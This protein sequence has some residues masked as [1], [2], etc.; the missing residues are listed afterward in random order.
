[1]R[2][3]LVD[4]QEKIL[5][6]TKKLV[7]WNRLGVEQVFTANS[8]ARARRLLEQEQIDIMLADI[9]M[10][11]ENGIELQ[12]WVSKVYPQVACI[13]LTSHADFS[14][15]QEAI[16]NGAVDYILQ[17]A[18]MSSI[19]A[20]LEK[21]IRN[22]EAK[23][24]I[25]HKSSSYDANLKQILKKYVFALFHQGTQFIQMEE[26][27]RDS[28]T[29]EE[30]WQYLPC[31]LRVY[32]TDSREIEERLSDQVKNME[33]SGRELRGVTSRLS[34]KEIGILL[35]GKRPCPERS[36]IESSLWT[37]FEPRLQN[38]TLYMGRCGR[39][40]LP[41]LAQEIL[42]FKTGRMLKENEI[43]H[44][45][46]AIPEEIRQPDSAVWGRWLIRQDLPL[47]KNQMT[48]LLHMAEQEKYLTVRYM[49]KL[50]YAFLE[51]CSVACYEQKHSL[52]ELFTGEFSHE[53]MLRAYTSVEELQKGIDFCLRRYQQM[54]GERTENTAASVQER[55]QEI[56][57]YLEENMDRMISR[58][59]AAKYVFLNED[60]FSRMFRRETGM[61]YKEYVVKQKMD[62]AEKL[63]ADTDMPIALVASKV[64]YD[65]YTNFTQTFRKT[66]GLT[67]TDYRKKYRIGSKS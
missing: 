36:V 31:L 48:N 18:A 20:A 51:A 13:F 64:G 28:H 44:V 38:K 21:C 46:A 10:P 1:M 8:G 7:N 27:K 63:L 5:E 37:L 49:Q 43:Y 42:D 52:G 19:E 54:F 67:P 3:L 45:D 66:K 33:I 59:E 6:A 62:Y 65:N 39:D 57:H 25:L 61:G 32:D 55:I 29:G 53:D 16:R 60:Y 26:W 4:D 22:L 9:E 56:L 35:Y 15:A 47:V 50:L 40:N 41:G 12:R 14:Y 30:E 58:R 24:K 34:E 23:R 17:P 2:V 11:G